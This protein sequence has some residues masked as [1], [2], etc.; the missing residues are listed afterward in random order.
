MPQPALN[1]VKTTIPSN[2]NVA[3][4][5][6]AS[7]IV[8]TRTSVRL[9]Q[10]SWRQH[11]SQGMG[12][13]LEPVSEAPGDFVLRATDQRLVVHVADIRTLSLVESKEANGGAQL[14]IEFA[15]N[16]S[17][18]PED[19]QQTDTPSATDGEAASLRQVVIEI[20][21][22]SSVT[23]MHTLAAVVR[24]ARLES[25]EGASHLQ[26]P[27]SCV[28]EYMTARSFVNHNTFR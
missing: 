5:L 24:L 27:D 25:E 8:E 17:R 7:R 11:R 9:A 20:D 3:A 6:R 19:V 12:V 4:L 16:L 28:T 18:G 15:P 13:A 1:H 26:V 21:A 2:A 23:Q 22:A 14:M 10:L